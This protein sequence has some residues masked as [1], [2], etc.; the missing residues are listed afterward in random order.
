LIATSSQ[1][2]GPYWHL[3]E[4]KN[5]ADL[6][7]FGATGE[8]LILTGRVTDG[9]G[10]PVTDACVEIWQPDPPASPQWQGWGRAA[11]D[12]SGV[13]RFTT[14]RPGPVPGAG[15]TLQAPHIAITLLARGL[16]KAL[17]T[18]AYFDG[19]SRNVDDPLLSSLEPARRKTVIAVA[20]G[21]EPGPTSV[22]RLDISLQGD[23][24]TVFLDLF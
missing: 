19:D 18:R 10:S 21:P 8:K 16:L 17:Y 6:T 24:E 14:L 5:W 12:Q 23:A 4:E 9:D 20:E 11:T 22:W 7:R 1:T 15:N 3:L 13:Y 2:I